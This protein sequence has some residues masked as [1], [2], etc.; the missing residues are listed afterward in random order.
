MTID[1]G[2][3]APTTCPDCGTALAP[4]ALSC[5]ACGALLHRAELGE[6]S[7]RA[8]A[9]AERRELEQERE[10][11]ERMLMLLPDAAPQARTLRLRLVELKAQQPSG[12]T[13]QGSAQK[14][15]GPWAAVGAFALLLVTKGKMLLLGLT[16]AKTAFS[17]LLALGA[18]WTI[19]GWKF[20]LG[21]VLSIYIH[22]MGHVI[23]LRR[24]GIPASAPMFVPFVGAFVRLN[25]H[26]DTAHDDAIA[27]LAGPIYGLGAALFCYAVYSLTSVSLFGALARSGAWL[28]LFNLIPI[29]QLD[30]G[31]A[32]NA[33]NREQRW[34]MVVIIAGVWFLFHETMLLL[35]LAGAIYR[36][37]TTPAPAEP[38]RRAMWSYILLV[39]ALGAL[40]HIHLPEIAAH[41]G[42]GP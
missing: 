22:E 14:A 13:S 28:N 38:D 4:G 33:L 23:A 36:G 12:V 25:R 9:H 34:G 24:L 7:A 5:V 1:V 42:F 30:G 17:M 20:A 19:W 35:L 29:W 32:F 40:T 27:G 8:Q 37:F 39:V 21:F 16:K 6:L 3:L 2:A 31:R 10:V 15:R 18:Y 26:P 11:L 41:S